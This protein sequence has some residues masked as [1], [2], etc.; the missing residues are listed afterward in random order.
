MVDTLDF[1]LSN[2]HIRQLIK[3]EITT[4]DFASAGKRLP[5]LYSEKLVRLIGEQTKL[6]NMVEFF[7]FRGVEAQLHTVDMP[8]RVLTPQTELNDHRLRREP[9]MVKKTLTPVWFNAKFVITDEALNINLEDKDLYDTIVEIMAMAMGRDYE[10][11]LIRG[12]K[13]GPATSEDR[14]FSGWAT[15]KVMIDQMYRLV[16][17]LIAFA[18]SD[19]TELDVS[20]YTTKYFNPAIAKQMILALPEERKWMT[21]AMRFMCSTHAYQDFFEAC[22]DQGTDWLTILKMIFGKPD[23]KY[24]NQMIEEIPWMENYPKYVTTTTFSSGGTVTL[25]DVPIVAGS[26]KLIPNTTGTYFTP[27]VDPD[28]YGAVDATGVI[29]HSGT[30]SSIPTDSET[31]ITAQGPDIV[32]MMPPKNFVFA[33]NTNT[34]TVETDRVVDDAYDLYVSRTECDTFIINGDD[35]VYGSGLINKTAGS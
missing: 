10:K 21:S 23:I 6:K 29:T 15:T 9:A 2:R 14:E 5:Y 30:A 7:A 12:D 26:E 34:V 24:Q 16:D 28:D 13:D 33:M 8:Y 25:A 17:G 27:Y 3:D 31:H 20:G 22:Q 11:L 1:R 35:I 32:V 4:G 18:K 19:G